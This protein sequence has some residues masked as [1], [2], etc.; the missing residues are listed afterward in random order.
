[1]RVNSGTCRTPRLVE[2]IGETELK[3]RVLSLR[4][5]IQ[6]CHIRD[7]N[8]GLPTDQ[9]KMLRFYVCQPKTV[10]NVTT[11]TRT[12]GLRINIFAL[13]FLSVRDQNSKMPHAGIE[14]GT[15]AFEDISLIHSTNV[16]PETQENSTK[17]AFSLAGP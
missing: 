13:Q 4:N 1:M 7:S 3:L 2:L 9:P 15:F 12:G 17:I 6:R 5:S 11:R 14:R 8:P 16:L 10:K